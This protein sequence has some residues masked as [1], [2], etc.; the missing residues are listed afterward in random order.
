[1][2]WAPGASSLTADTKLLCQVILTCGVAH[3]PGALRVVMIQAG[4]DNDECPGEWTEQ[5][6][7]VLWGF[8]KHARYVSRTRRL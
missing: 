6:H 5:T 7:A 3:L 2:Q 1:M 4:T 8:I